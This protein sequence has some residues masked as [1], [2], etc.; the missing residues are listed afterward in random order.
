MRIYKHTVADTWQI[1]STTVYLLVTYT[2]NLRIYKKVEC[3]KAN[4]KRFLNSGP[5]CKEPGSPCSVLT[6]NKNKN[7]CWNNVDVRK[8]NCNWRVAGDSLWT[9][10]K[11]KNYRKPSH[12]EGGMTSLLWILPPD[13][14]SG[15]QSEYRKNFPLLLAEGGKKEPFWNN[16][17]NFCKKSWPQEKL[18]Y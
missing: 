2:Q 1:R 5:L 7:I 9:S 11:V 10:L 3:N 13:S 17:E 4:K 6:T 12:G 15:F 8:P 14:W 16:P 18:L